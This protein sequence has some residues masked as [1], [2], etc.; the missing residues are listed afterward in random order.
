MSDKEFL[1]DEQLDEFKAS[2]GDPSEVPEP[3]NKETPKRKGD[4][5]VEDDPKDAPTAVKV[6]GT[7]AGMINAMMTKMNEMQPKTLKAAY[8]NMM[9]AMMPKNEEVELE[10]EEEVHSV[11]SLPKVTSEDIDISEDVAAM[12]A[13]DDLSE[14]FKQKVHTVFEA[15]VVAKVNEQ[16]ETISANFESELAE[17]VD[18]IRT[19]MA[20]KLDEYTDYVVEQ[21]MDENRLAV[22]HGIKAEMVENF[23]SGMK[24][25]FTEHYI[26]I[27]DEKVDVVEE[28]AAKAEELEARL[29]EEIERSVEMRSVVEQYTKDSLIEQISEDLTET[30]KAKFK[31][32][33]EGI[34]FADEDTFVSKISTIKE[35]YFGGVEETTHHYEFDE[36]EPLEEEAKPRAASGPMSAY[37]S[38]ISRSIKK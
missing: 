8:G 33:A 28:L 21:W 3:S 24:E 5:D 27:P 19:E 4:K 22:E 1:E 6:P 15:A 16:L 26:D 12:F 38:A 37:V 30:Q 20:E 35:S 17:E 29:N 36:A 10:F 2:F 9:S 13:G 11:R 18:S 14:D 23:M 34:D 32:L 7:K 31:T 25:L